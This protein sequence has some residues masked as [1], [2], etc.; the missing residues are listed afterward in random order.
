MPGVT[1]HIWGRGWPCWTSVR[2]E[3]LEPESVQC[4]S[5]GECLGGKTE[6]S[7]CGST[8]IEA[9]ERGWDRAFLE[10]ETWKRENARNVNKEKY[11]IITII[12]IIIIKM[13]G[14]SG[15]STYGCQFLCP[16]YFT[17]GMTLHFQTSFPSFL[18]HKSS[19]TFLC[20]PSSVSY[21]AF[22]HLE[23]PL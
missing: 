16:C 21:M 8:F 19:L 20:S 10:G 13:P 7:G 23:F 17:F 6:V 15:S 14:V 3:A 11:P 2:G 5:V 1:G 12:I 4:P 18:G 9:G 22:P